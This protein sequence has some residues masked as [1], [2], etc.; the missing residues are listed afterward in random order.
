LEE[1]LS[2]QEGVD[3]LQ[4]DIEVGT[5]GGS[6]A[7]KDKGCRKG[8]ANKRET[9]VL[10]QYNL[11]GGCGL[12]IRGKDA[13]TGEKEGGKVAQVS[14]KRGETLLGWTRALR[15]SSRLFNRLGRRRE[16]L[17]KGDK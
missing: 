4:R 6:V 9:T 17:W 15:S 14:G 7:K 11:K 5:E 12:P 3:V 16:S 10:S 13:Q 1:E 2:S 8:G